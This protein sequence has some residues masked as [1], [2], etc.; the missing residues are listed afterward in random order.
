MAAVK[1]AVKLNVPDDNDVAVALP[2][3]GVCNVGLVAN[4]KLPE[5]V[6]SE[7]VLAKLALVG[8]DKNVCIPV[9][10]VNALCLALNI[11]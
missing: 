5:P 8:V 4:T 2:N 10:N 6:S 9:P 1:A 7:I 3:T 11:A